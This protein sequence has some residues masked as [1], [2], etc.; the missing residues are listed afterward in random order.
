MRAAMLVIQ[1]GGADIKFM[2]LLL[3]KYK[4][5]Y[6]VLWKTKRLQDPSHPYAKLRVHLTPGLRA[7]GR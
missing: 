3:D 2:Q 6:R 1:S 7:G 5:S 4:Y